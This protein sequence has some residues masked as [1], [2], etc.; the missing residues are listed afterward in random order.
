MSQE[1]QSST[2]I[3]YSSTFYIRH[4]LIISLDDD[5]LSTPMKRREHGGC[6][7]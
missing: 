7:L 2:T 1:T 5:S 3:I 4:L 6:D